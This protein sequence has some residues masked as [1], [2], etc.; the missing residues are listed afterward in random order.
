MAA[1]PIEVFV[2]WKGNLV[3]T[4]S[5]QLREAL[6]K[7]V[8]ALRLVSSALREYEEEEKEGAQ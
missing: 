7:E 4:A 8:L 2:S 5:E 1:T 6:G 3:K